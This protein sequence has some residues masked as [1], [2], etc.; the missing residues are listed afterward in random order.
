[1]SHNIAKKFA[2]E[3]IKGREERVVPI[4][5]HG[6]TR[7]MKKGLFWDSER[8]VYI[9]HGKSI[10]KDIEILDLKDCEELK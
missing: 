6:V 4:I 3:Y 8:E 2:C 5:Y 7:K 9:L 10:L 1:M